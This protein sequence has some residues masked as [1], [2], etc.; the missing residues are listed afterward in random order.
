MDNELELTKKRLAELSRRAYDRGIC[1]FS[2][3]S[4]PASRR[5]SAACTLPSPVLDGGYS[6]AER[7]AAVFGGERAPICCLEIAPT[8]PK[9]AEELTHRDYL[10]SLMGLGLRRSVLG[11][12][13]LAEGRAYVFCL[14]SVAGHIED[15]LTQ[16]RRT[17][18]RVRRAENLPESVT[19]PPEETTLTA[20]S[21]RLDALVSAAFNLSRAE[22]QARRGRARVREH[23]PAPR[24]PR[25]GGDMVSVRGP[26]LP[27]RGALGETRKAGCV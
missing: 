24:L 3:F 23:L 12:I 14:E 20:A 4:R 11:D 2:E 17:N 22:R 8:A 19:A 7:R 5:S 16:V 13:V 25:P 15:G 21:E 26:A 1:T 10:G 9:F 6:E 18:V 27:L